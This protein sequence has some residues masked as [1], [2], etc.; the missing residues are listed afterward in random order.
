MQ[1][2]VAE[3]LKYHE[4]I[5]GGHFANIRST[6]GDTKKTKLMLSKNEDDNMKRKKITT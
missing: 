4:Y 5:R 6:N 1:D 2:L 3:L